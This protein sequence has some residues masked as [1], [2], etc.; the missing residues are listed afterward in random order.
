VP[1]EGTPRPSLGLVGLAALP[2]VLVLVGVVVA[3]VVAPA[4]VVIA[5]VGVVLGAANLTLGRG[6]RLL[7]LLGGR[8]SSP[9][10]D[11]R[12]FNVLEGLCVENGLAMPRVRVRD[13]AA[14]NAL[15]LASGRGGLVLV[16][17]QGLL[18]NL[19]RIQ[20]E[21]V[22][23]DI[24]AGAKRG[25]VKRA[26]LIARALGATASVSVLGASLAWRFTEPSRQFRTDREACRM[27]CFPPGL[28]SAL[29]VL[30]DRPTEPAGLPPALAR[31]SAPYWLVPLAIGKPRKVRA[32]ELDLGLRISAL[33]EL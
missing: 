7:G 15:L 19:D 3:I 27:T 32:G 9:A 12:L 22:L 18:E 25:D 14:A 21:A 20:L 4:L 24:L 31:L 13:D 30:S 6:S 33:A 11:P 28:L 29:Q 1:L 16:C 10:Q 8:E 5:L 23:A 17:T 2:L 26:A